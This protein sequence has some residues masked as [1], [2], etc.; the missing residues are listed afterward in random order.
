ML[1]LYEVYL[2]LKNLQDSVLDLCTCRQDFLL[3]TGNGYLLLSLSEK[4]K[5]R[6]AKEKE[7]VLSEERIL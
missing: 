2:K 5:L 1:K 3:N 4:R 6:I 7:E